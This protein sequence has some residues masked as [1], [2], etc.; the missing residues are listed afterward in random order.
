MTDPSLLAV[1]ELTRR[2]F[3][4]ADA[5]LIAPHIG[6][7][8]LAISDGRVREETFDEWRERFGGALR[9]AT[10]E[11]WDDLEPPR[12]GVSADGTMAWLV[13]VVEMAG[14]RG[15]KSFQSRSARLTVFEKR[16]GRWRRVVNASTAED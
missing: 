3:I 10:F 9:A 11:R 16:D 5:E 12:C 7:R 6:E 4:E 13:E 2:S 14:S 15:G 1:H 8:E